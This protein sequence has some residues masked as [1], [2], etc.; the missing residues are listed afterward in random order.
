MKI[1][2]I[3]AQDCLCFQETRLSF[4]FFSFYDMPGVHSITL[5][6]VQLRSFTVSDL[7]F[8]QGSFSVPERYWEKWSARLVP[9]K[10]HHTIPRY[11]T[12]GNQRE[13]SLASTS[14]MYIGQLGSNCS[15]YSLKKEVK[16]RQCPRQNGMKWLW[17]EWP[18]KPRLNSTLTQS[19]VSSAMVT[20]EWPFYN[21]GDS[22]HHFNCCRLTW[23]NQLQ[24][25][26]FWE[27]Y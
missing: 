5:R 23:S 12:S 21:R 13:L 6:L 18:Q 20:V 19:K 17:L 7:K 3:S 10:P 1:T 16:Y 4:S 11:T 9:C 26:C 25:K 8:P 22:P 27:W 24:V 2:M 15:R 14:T